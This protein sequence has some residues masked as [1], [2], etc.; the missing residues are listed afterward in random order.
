MTSPIKHMNVN[1]I[2]ARA[3]A[4][5]T[6]AL[7]RQALHDEE[8]KSLGGFMGKQR[9]SKPEFFKFIG[10]W[11]EAIGMVAQDIGGLGGDEYTSFLSVDG[12]NREEIAGQDDDG[13]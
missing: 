1:K 13:F 3:E 9:I 5:R 2:L 10:E 7:R 4:L 12:P 11:Q 8:F 6:E